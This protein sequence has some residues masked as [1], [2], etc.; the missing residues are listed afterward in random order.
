MNKKYFNTKFSEA[1]EILKSI[2]SLKK[3]IENLKS[4]ISVKKDVLNSAYINKL[5]LSSQKENR[6]KS[7]MDNR[8]F[9]YMKMVDF[10][11][12]EDV[13]EKQGFSVNKDSGFVISEII[14]KPEVKLFNK[15]I[16]PSN[17]KELI[18]EYETTS[19]SNLLSFSFKS[20]AGLPITPKNIK[21]E[22]GNNIEDFFEP[23][24]RYYNRNASNVYVNN[25]FFYPKKITKIYVTFNEDY[26]LNSANCSL[27]SCS[28]NLSKDSFM[29]VDVKNTGKISNFNIF[30]NSDENN[31]PLIFE[32]TEDNSVYKSV[33]F[34]KQ[35]AVIELEKNN[36]FKIRIKSDYESVEQKEFTETK[37]TNISVK[38]MVVIENVH[39][40]DMIGKIINFDVVLTQ[41][42][43]KKLRDDFTKCFDDEMLLTDFV[44]NENGVFKVKKE[45][46]SI[47]N[48]P[49]E[50]ILNM[51]LQ[52][53]LSELKNN[54]GM[55]NFYIHE[56][57][58]R[59]YFSSFMLEYNFFLQLETE[60]V[61]DS[62]P[63]DMLT[64][65]LFD[66]QIKG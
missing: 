39:S 3:E 47:V 58:K 29:D 5:H 53:D 62:I 7:L 44:S 14:K 1:A 15:M 35:E 51:I 45:F 33:V 56:K 65:F 25:F 64:P 17:T 32:F 40:F 6:I 21:L 57:D 42:A 59:I 10:I 52:D 23:N 41:S 16:N 36:D 61:V 4:E 8:H 34:E 55:F 66:L 48:E 27:Y 24:F 30:K 26:D 37:K 11:T 50:D 2:S 28:F 13:F 46:V 60:F 9:R 22:Y 31:V 12:E 49:T 19:Y 20:K 38:D 43:Y 54:K 18:F 63:N